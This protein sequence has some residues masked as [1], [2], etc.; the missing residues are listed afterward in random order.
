MKKLIVGAFGSCS[1]Q[2]GSRLRH[3][4][5][6]VTRLGALVLLALVSSRASAQTFTT[7]ASFN[8]GNGG[9]DLFN[10]VALS[11]DGST[12]YGT[13]SYFGAY[14]DGTVFSVPTSG[15]A[16]TTLL[17]FSGTSGNYLGAVPNSVL[18]SGSTL[19]GTTNEGGAYP[20][21]VGS[22]DGTVFSMPATGGTLTT[23]LSFN[24]TNG[25]WPEGSL[26]LNGS[27][28][29]G[30]TYLGGTLYDGTVYSLS[31]G[32]G[33]LTQ[34]FPFGAATRQLYG[35]DPQNGFT[36][37]GSTLYGMAASG[38]AYGPNGG[39][40]TV[41]SIPVGGGTPTS[42]LSFSGTNGQTPCGT[43][44][45]SG[46]TIYGMTT[47]GGT[48]NV[49]GQASSGDG[50][51][52]SMPISGGT[53]TTLLSFGGTNGN[54]PY[55]GLTLIGSTLYGTT[56]LGGLYGDGNIF[57]INTNGSGYRDL[58]DF[59]DTNGENPQ[60]TLTRSGWTLYGTT[61]YGGSG[62]L[63]T[64][65]ALNVAPATVGLSTVS[66]AT[67]I[68]GGT[69]TFGMAVS[70]SPTSA[71]N[72]NYTLGA[73]VQSGT[74]TLG[75]ITS[76][77]GSLAPSASQTCA[78]P[79][80]S[81][82]LGNNIISFTASD[83]NS[84]NLSVTTTATLTVLG[85][86]A[87]DLSVAGGNNQSVFVGV[88]GV[89]A[90]LSLTDSG[91]SLSPLDVN[92]LS[93]GL[94]GTTGTAVIASGGSGTYTATLSTGMVGLSQSQSFSL[95]AGD[96]QA[97]PGANPLGTLTQSV[98]GLNV[99]NHAAGAL[100]GGT[101]TIPPVIVGYGSPVTSNTL[102]ISNTA[103]SP[104]GALMT[105][106][107]TS[108]GN[109]TLN[110]ANNVAASDGTGSLS[111]TLATGQGVG[112]FTQ[113]NVALTYADASTY[114]GALS[115]LGTTA[116]TITGDVLGHAAPSL[117]VQWQ[118]S[119]VIVGATGIITA[120]SLSNG[121]LNQS[122]L[123]ALDVNSLGAGVSGGTG[124]ALIASGSS[125]SYTAA[126]NTGTLGTHPQTF[127]L[128]VGD[129]HTL[130]GA[131]APTNLSLTATLT[132]LGHA[133]PNL[134][135]VSGNNQTVI[136]GA[137][138]INAGL[139]L[140]N[141]T[142]NQSGL[143][144]LD[145]NS[146]GVLVF[147]S[148]GGELVA[149]GTA[150]PYTA[151]LNTSTVGTQIDTFTL[152]VGDDH[153][154]SG[155]SAPINVS[156]SATLTVL[157]HAAPTLSVGTGNNQTVIVGATGI[158]AGLNLTNG[159]SAQSGL[160]SLDVNSLGVLVFGS[161]GG[162]LVAS[163]CSQSYTA[164]L[165]I[166][167]FGPQTET[168]SM[169]VGDDHTLA[170]ASAPTGLSTTA[171]LTVL[172]H[173]NASLSST[174][175]QTTQ[176]I[177]F[178]NV[179]KGAAVPSR[180]FTIYNRAAKAQAAYTA[181]LKLTNFTATGDA[182]LTTNLAAFNGLVA[183]SGTTCTAALNTSN[184]TST[185]VNTITMS[186]SQ[187][188]DDGG[189]PG[190]GN[191][192]NGGITVTLQGNVGNATADAS[193]SP[194]S[195]GA[196]LTAPVAQNSSYANLESKVTTTTGSGGQSMVGSTATILAGTASVSTTASMA[197]RTAATNEGLA[198][199]VLDL[200]GMGVVDGQTKNGSVHTDTFVLQMTYSPL[201]VEQR[202]GLSDVAAAQ[203]GLIQ[204]DYL[205]EGSSD[206][207]EPAV[208]GNFG[209]SNDTFVGVG[210]WNGDT[211]LGDW[212]VNTTNDTVWAVVNHNSEF[213]VVPEPSTLVLFG[214]AMGLIGFAWRR[215]A[216]GKTAQPTAF[217]QP[218]RRRS[219]RSVLAFTFVPPGEHGTAG[220][221]IRPIGARF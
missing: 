182:A 209:S 184:Y 103:A 28:L 16:S 178:G 186:A 149:S 95:I 19:Y 25:Q 144:A 128:N 167:T 51:V 207:W 148:T 142:L 188:A 57:S 36:L 64:V 97:L 150:Q 119:T 9:G 146:L 7:L 165:S 81:L 83:P 130:P 217:D 163:G 124:G 80:T 52:F 139:N 177:N 169:N 105:T 5:G 180:S 93:S 191:N 92:T 90:S 63:G 46:T 156:T 65:F 195:F 164:S 96:Q 114:A 1:Y 125:Q 138:G 175:T 213:A 41:Y 162:K 185:G 40:G 70:N 135:V 174:A 8:G 43:L 179:L 155:A 82:Q 219:A 49:S 34:L 21:S 68:S 168:F 66:N 112:A 205:D 161:T 194:T 153:T 23:L 98:T 32:G 106:G 86:A 152:N 116:V 208:L 140:S 10:G 39:D 53:L 201:I 69:A 13:A 71:Y 158:T 196:A 218:Q 89:T 72:L 35:W 78:V 137:S 91:T 136:V 171:A 77:T 204:M 94:T 189:L 118:Q 109:V 37:V 215:R 44:I 54:R 181:N 110:N 88:G 102:T 133:A 67:I 62:N 12:L 132:V 187:L 120:F 76:P 17:S 122:G 22:G 6:Q 30:T 50:T 113:S 157:G 200:T 31:V 58:F 220:S 47:Y 2:G 14:G 42:L 173:S 131:S 212:G 11:A 87:P 104:G 183:G 143:A 199:D 59:N 166:G 206:P 115:N 107:S 26:T 101:L 123:A 190:A 203:A 214:V 151:T 99:Y 147:G 202:T 126:L 211:R 48:T 192:N 193:N 38:G 145:V 172:D 111:A 170:G 141:G 18:L 61:V 60:S 159:T 198:S 121:N 221:L 24:G 108:L 197:W 56:S 154:I 4:M 27:T 84:S 129:D 15:G 79:A 73:L 55:G 85:H 75:M 134:S 3:G 29:I 100:S 74:A 33:S 176:T 210:A 45:V 117:S 216:A 20:G 160:A 127:S